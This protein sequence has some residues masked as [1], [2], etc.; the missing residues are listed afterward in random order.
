[1]TA[2]SS[3]QWNG[4]ASSIIAVMALPGLPGTQP[5]HAA[6]VPGEPAT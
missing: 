2:G 6:Q 4:I 3:V 5:D 1:M